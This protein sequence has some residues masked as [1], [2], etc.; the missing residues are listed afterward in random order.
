MSDWNDYKTDWRVVAF[1]KAEKEENERRGLAQRLAATLQHRVD[2]MKVEREEGGSS[3]VQV[4]QREIVPAEGLDGV[5]AIP[6]LRHLPIKAQAAVLMAMGVPASVVAYELGVGRTTLWR[7]SQKDVE[8]LRYR[9]SSEKEI[10]DQLKSQAVAAL[11][12]AM[13]DDDSNVRLKA[14][15]AVF[16]KIEL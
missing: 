11:A 12:R 7:W 6:G 10:R 3:M 15:M 8:F 9:R 1:D 13:N 14:A 4:I 5:D 16:Q 2:L